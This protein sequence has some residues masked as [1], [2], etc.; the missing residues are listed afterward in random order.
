MQQR[1]VAGPPAKV[2]DED[3]LVVIESGFV[4]VRCRHGLHFKINPIKACSGEGL[5][6]ARDSIG[7]IVFALRADKPYRA[8]HH[9]VAERGVELLFSVAA[10]IGKNAGN[11][12]FESVMTAKHRCSS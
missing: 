6:Q 1:E 4:G 10:Q 9:G 8:A 12:I 2:A 11:E 5:A 3:Q 7:L